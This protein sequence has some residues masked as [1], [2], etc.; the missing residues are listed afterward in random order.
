MLEYKKQTS[1]FNEIS[2]LSI[3]FKC[4]RFTLL[5]I[6]EGAFLFE[7]KQLECRQH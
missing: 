3:F 5:N 6:P 7:Y 4:V 2:A 1:S